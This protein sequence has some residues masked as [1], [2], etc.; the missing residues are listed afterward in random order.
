MNDIVTRC[1]GIGCKKRDTCLRYASEKKDGQHYA[2]LSPDLF[3]DCESFIE[4]DR[5]KGKL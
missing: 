5:Y 1:V 2:D 4:L 3:N